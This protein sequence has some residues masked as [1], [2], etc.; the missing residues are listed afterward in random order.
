M[1]IEEGGVLGDEWGELG[2]PYNGMKSDFE[3]SPFHGDKST[4]LIR[5]V[6]A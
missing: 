2:A 3:L 5:S 6:F 4:C 1:K